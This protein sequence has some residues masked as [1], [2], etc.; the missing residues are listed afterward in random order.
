MKLEL[1]GWNEIFEGDFRSIAQEGAVSGRVVREDRGLYSVVTS[2]GERQGEISGGFRYAHQ[3]PEEFPSVGDWVV[4]EPISG[5]AKVRIVE[6]LPRRTVFKRNAAGRTSDVQIVAANVDIVFLVVGLDFDFNPRRTERFITLAIESGARPV[7][8]LNKADLADEIDD[9]VR[10]IEGVSM[11]LPIEVVSATEGNGIARLRGYIKPSKTAV[12]LGSS[13]VGKST[14]V[15][16][17][18]GDAV[19]ATGVVRTDDSRGRH[20]TTHRELII[21]SSGGML[22]DTPGMREIQLTGDIDNIAE[23][24][25]DIDALAHACKFRN[26]QHGE[27]SGCAIGKAIDSGELDRKRYNSYLKLQREMV[28]NE[29][30]VNESTTF[31]QRRRSKELS[32]T[33]KRFKM[34]KDSD[35]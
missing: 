24:F 16:A 32:K 35:R 23:T 33:Y 14:I 15:N 25:A 20:T 29:R 19:M 3:R 1:L 31:E 28:Y 2:D 18:A 11:G 5:E 21:L 22:I 9:R 30:R 34:K 4:T 12:F 10:E 6:V 26:C 7:I 17:L 27:E 8:V 13:G